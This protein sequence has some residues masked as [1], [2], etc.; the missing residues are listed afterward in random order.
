MMSTYSFIGLL[1]T[2]GCEMLR[3][4][5]RYSLLF[6][7]T[8][9][10]LTCS[11]NDLFYPNPFQLPKGTSQISL[12]TRQ[13]MEGVYRLVDGSSGLGVE[14]V[15]KASPKKVSFFSNSNGIF[16]IL[17]AGLDS[18]S[19]L[20]FAGFWRVSEY[21][22]SGGIRF[23]IPKDQV[24]KLVKQKITAGLKLTGDFSNGESNQQIV[25]QYVRDFSATKKVKPLVIFGH[26]GIQTNGNPPFMENSL[27]AFRQAEDY[28]ANSLEVDVRMTKD[29]VPVLYHDQDLNIRLTQ[30]GGI[31]TD[32]DKVTWNLLKNAVRLIDGQRIPSVEEALTLA[33]DSTNLKYVWLD[34][35]GNPDVFKY[36]E[37]VI[38]RAQAHALAK[39]NKIIF[40]TDIPS[41]GV[42]AE[43]FKQPSYAD[44][45]LMYELELDK[46]I[47][48]NFKYWGPRW[49]EGTLN[50]DVK[51]AHSLGMQVY[52]WTVN[53]EV[54]TRSYL[55]NG[56]FDGLISDFPAYAVYYYYV[57]P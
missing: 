20:Q 34:I 22:S 42:L 9:L 46:T 24:V 27:E 4:C 26:H 36:M 52:T 14:F 35:K 51:R 12:A 41:E 18:D 25:L 56:D 32:I 40:I 48:L 53:S 16:V 10:N 8:F 2:F 45:P 28:G 15:C 55:E 57:K 29:N 43:Y 5:F 50:A 1:F 49:T 19:T 44:L 7:I 17:Q 30:K 39:G 21:V 6:V 13:A 11:Q 33:V 38:R 23:E 47:A 54:Y 31:L 3:R 37:P